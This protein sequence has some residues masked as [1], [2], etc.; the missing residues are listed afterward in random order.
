MFDV[1]EKYGILGVEMEAT[2][3]YG[4]AAE[5]GAKST[6]YLYRFR[7]YSGTHEQTT[8]EE[9]QLTFNDMIEIALE[10]V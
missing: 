1:M 2:G 8:A 6:L 9:R 4:V 10:S 7:P 3:I 5:Y